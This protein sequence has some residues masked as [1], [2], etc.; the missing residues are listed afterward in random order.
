[1]KKITEITKARIKLGELKKPDVSTI[2][3]EGIFNK[4]KRP[5]ERILE[6]INKYEDIN[7]NDINN[8]IDEMGDNIVDFGDGKEVYFN[9]PN[10][11]LHYLKDGYI[12]NFNKEKKYIEEKLTIRK[13]YDKYVNLYVK[14]L[15]NL[16]KTLFTKKIIRQRFNY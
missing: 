1:M 3:I 11:F 9:D 2:P 6:N 16:K 4:I 13:K 12:N 15:N 8:L 10:N 7:L 5:K 14:Y